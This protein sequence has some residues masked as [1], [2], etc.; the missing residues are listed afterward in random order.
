MTIKQHGFSISYQRSS[1]PVR[2]LTKTLHL[3]Y[4]L[5]PQPH[6][7]TGHIL[8][9]IVAPPVRKLDNPWLHKAAKKK[10]C[11]ARCEQRPVQHLLSKGFLVELHDKQ[12]QWQQQEMVPSYD[13]YDNSVCVFLWGEGK[14]K[15]NLLLCFLEKPPFQKT[16]PA[17]CRSQ[18]SELWESQVGWCEK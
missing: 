13:Y 10:I 8:E 7:A 17:M 5:P 14:R 12:Q 11:L 6:P 16:F 15:C 9:S 3:L 4:W 2:W 18:P 1:P